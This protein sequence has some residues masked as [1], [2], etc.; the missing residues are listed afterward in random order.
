[1]KTRN[2]RIALR[3]SS[4]WRWSEASWSRRGRWA[5]WTEPTS[6]PIS[7]TATVYFAA[8]RSASWVYRSVPLDAI[9]P[10]SNRVKISF[11]VDDAVKVPAEARGAIL[12]PS[13][14]PHG[15][16]S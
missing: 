5:R 3:W 12:S 10:E 4:C 11:W 16:S 14:S 9:E 7:T 6:W 15:P 13:W 8:T 1:M 2:V